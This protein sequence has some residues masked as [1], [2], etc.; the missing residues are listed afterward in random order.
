MECGRSFISALGL[1]EPL[2][3]SGTCQKKSG[4]ARLSRVLEGIT[5]KSALTFYRDNMYNASL[6]AR[7]VGLMTLEAFALIGSVFTPPGGMSF[8]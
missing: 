5:N 7:P 4:H 2:W 8:P 1:P 6:S 3:D